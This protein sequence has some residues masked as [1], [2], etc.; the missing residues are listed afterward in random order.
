ME[1]KLVNV[2]VNK[3][4]VSVPV[5]STI[6]EAAKKVGINIPTLCYIKHINEIGACRVCV[7]EVEGMKNLVASCSTPVTE[8]MK[9]TTANERI[10]S[11][12]K[13]NI[14]LLLS[15]HNIDC[16]SCP[17]SLSCELQKLSREYCCD[18]K[19]FA[20][21]KPE[22]HLDTSSLCL[23]RDSSKCI[24]CQ[25]CIAVCS[26]VQT[27]NALTSNERG[28]NTV[29]GCAFGQELVNSTCVEC[30]QCTVV[31]PTGALYEKQDQRKVLKALSNPNLT[32][33]VAAAPSVRVALGE[34]FGLPVGTNVEKKMI[35]SLKRLG[36]SKVFD[37]NFG[38]DLTIVEE[39][40]EFVTRLKENKLPMY[41]SCCPGWI[42]FV[43]NFYP[44]LK[45]LI[46]SC[47]SPQQMFG[48]VCKTY[49]AEKM[50]LDPKNIFVVTIMPCTAKK[51]ELA[52]PHQNAAGVNDVDASLTTREFAVLLKQQGLFLPELEDGNFDM[53]FG[54]YSGA[55]VIFGNTGGVM[56]AALRTI[57]EKSTNKTLENPEFLLVRGEEGIKESEYEVN[58]EKIKVAVVSGLGNARKLIESIKKGEKQ[59]HFIEVMACPGGC[60]C[61]G[62][63]P[64]NPEVEHLGQKRAKGLYESDK[65]NLQRSSHKNPAIINFYK[66]YLGEP[67]GEKAH[68]ILHTKLD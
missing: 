51:S 24:N 9:I 35:T 32:T 44:E 57:V 8:G 17:R 28:F 23:E 36:F 30:G 14:E 58:G 39:A 42:N 18:S 55:G 65:S 25:K 11:A 38:A 1:E 7:V 45:P 34:E 2:I 46:S 48:A 60:V 37:I 53:P 22:P 64:R 63:M 41:T 40:Q 59:F 5:G 49:Y 12:R 47:K 31:C 29:V 43:K 27:V 61:G 4:S 66:E 19:T 68:K 15:S 54:M 62:G 67:N 13:T 6:L 50:G 26:K 56:E 21:E 52:R 33:I 16:L 20:G 3:I 10:Y